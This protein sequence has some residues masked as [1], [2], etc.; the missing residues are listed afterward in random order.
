MPLGLAVAC[1][2]LGVVLAVARDGWMA[3]FFAVAVSGDIAVLPLL[4]LVILPTWLLVS[5][6]PEMLVSP[7]PP[8]MT[9]TTAG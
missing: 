7:D 9:E 4:C 3:F 5:R 1:G 6:A 2:I 8:R